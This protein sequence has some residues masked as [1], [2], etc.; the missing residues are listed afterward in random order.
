MTEK[1]TKKESLTAPSFQ[2]DLAIDNDLAP[3]VCQ[4][5]GDTDVN[6][7]T[8]TLWRPPFHAFLYA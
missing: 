8:G 7:T 3:T 1:H 6:K 2:P 5:A 4:G